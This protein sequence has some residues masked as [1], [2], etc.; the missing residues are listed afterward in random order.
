MVH[1]EETS[2]NLTTASLNCKCLPCNA[3]CSFHLK[4]FGVLGSLE[5]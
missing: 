5:T 1:K 4:S 3:N 2:G